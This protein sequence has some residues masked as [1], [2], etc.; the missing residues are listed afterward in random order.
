MGRKIRPPRFKTML[1]SG[2]GIMYVRQST[3]VQVSK[4]ADSSTHQRDRAEYARLWGWPEHTIKPT[5]EETGRN[6]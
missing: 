1:P 2:R 6:G 4:N 5:T 3:E